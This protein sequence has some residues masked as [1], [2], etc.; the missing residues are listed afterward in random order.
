M[1]TSAVIDRQGKNTRAHQKRWPRSVAPRSSTWRRINGSYRF[2]G[3]SFPLLCARCAPARGAPLQAQRRRYPHAPCCFGATVIW[4]ATMRRSLP[5]R[6]LV[7]TMFFS[8][9]PLAQGHE[10]KGPRVLSGFIH[11][12]DEG[13]LFGGSVWALV[14]DQPPPPFCLPGLALR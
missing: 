1:S 4:P 13:T 2:M 5:Q 11:Q 8:P 3:S 12:L 10:S 14:R 7:I 6:P 9:W